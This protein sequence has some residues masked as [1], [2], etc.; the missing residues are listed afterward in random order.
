MNLLYLTPAAWAALPPEV[1]GECDGRPVW[2]DP[3]TGAVVA[4]V[5]L[6]DTATPSL[7]AEVLELEHRLRAHLGVPLS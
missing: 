6:L 2:A 7:L 4:R 1:K 5:E 3:A